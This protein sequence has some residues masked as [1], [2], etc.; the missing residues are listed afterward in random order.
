M[1]FSESIVQSKISQIAG[2]SQNLR[3]W[4]NPQKKTFQIRSL[5]LLH[6]K[7]TAEM[8]PLTPEN[9]P[10]TSLARPRIL[11]RPTSSSLDPAA[12]T[13]ELGELFGE[14]VF[15]IKNFFIGGGVE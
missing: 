4:K 6:H 3:F 1:R 11:A 7:F 13:S 2:F 5:P 14:R 9:D 8:P 12:A 10:A 15:H